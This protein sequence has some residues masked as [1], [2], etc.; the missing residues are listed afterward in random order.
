MAGPA[1][2][3]IL[4][5]AAAGCPHASAHPGQVSIAAI[6]KATLCLLN[7][8]RAAHGMPA[9][10]ENRRLDS[11]SL[12]HSRDM[13]RKRYFQHGDVVGRIRR[14]GYLRGAGS[15]GVG[16]NI[17]WGSG[18]YSTPASIVNLWMHSPGHRAN[19]LSKSFRDIGIGVVRG[20]PRRGVAGAATY[21]TDF[22][23]R[24]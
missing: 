5:L 4:A 8:E 2:S 16:E 14:S 9:L 10:D 20:A 1:L 17:A 15:W 6:D 11:A 23:F 12:R 7:A 13:V 19:I 18:S 3:A 22:G 24:G 21:T